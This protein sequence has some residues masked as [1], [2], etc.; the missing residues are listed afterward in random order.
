M[1]KGL[2]FNSH[3]CHPAIIPTHAPAR[4]CPSQGIVNEL[5][6]NSKQ[7]FWLAEI[8]APSWQEVNF[9]HE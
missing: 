5:N 8:A 6:M 4:R 2:S 9:A 3:T 7:S 1:T